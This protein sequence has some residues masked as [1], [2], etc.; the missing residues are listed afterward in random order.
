MIRNYDNISTTRVYSGKMIG[1]DYAIVGKQFAKIMNTF[2]NS[3]KILLQIISTWSRS[4]QCDC[5]FN[6]QAYQS[7]SSAG[8]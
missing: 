7:E 8:V 6:G 1:N 2:E 3:S 4:V 5:S